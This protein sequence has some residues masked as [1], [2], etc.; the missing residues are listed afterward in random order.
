MANYSDLIRKPWETDFSPFGR[1]TH[2]ARERDGL[3]PPAIKVGR[4]S[5]WVAGELDAVNTAIIA[6]RSDDEIRALVRDLVAQRT[7]GEGQ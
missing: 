7:A 6:G 3:G 4:M 5:A 2:Y 1:A